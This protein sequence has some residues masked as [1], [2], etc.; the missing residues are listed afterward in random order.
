MVTTRDISAVHVCGD[1]GMGHYAIGF[2]SDQKAW[3]V[4]ILW[5]RLD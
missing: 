5:I 3:Q 1:V 4:L 2:T